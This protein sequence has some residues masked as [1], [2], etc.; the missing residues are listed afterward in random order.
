MK[1]HYL[2]VSVCTLITLLFTA[3]AKINPPVNELYRFNQLGFYP[4]QEKIAVLD[5]VVSGPFYIKEYHSG[6]VVYEGLVSQ[7]R[8][9]AFSEKETVVIPFSQLRTKGTYFIEIPEIGKSLPFEIK[10]SLFSSLSKASLKAFYLQRSGTDIEAEFAGKW[11]R[12]AGH[13]DTLVRIH[14][15][16]ATAVRPAESLISSPKGWYDAGDYNKYIVNSGFT[17]GILLSLYEDYPQYA[18]SVSVQIP[19]SANQ[20]PDLLDEI[21]WNLEWMLSMQDPSDGGVYHKLTTPSFEGMIKP[22]ECKQPRYVIEKSVTATLDFAASMAQA[23]RVFAPFEKDYPEVSQKM[24]QASIRA[25][26]WALQHPDALYNQRKMNAN[27]KPAVSTGGYEDRSATDEFFWAA[28]E[29]YI[30]TGNDKYTSYVKQYLPESFILP[31]WG[32][33]YG[34]AQ[35]SLIRHRDKLEKEMGSLSDSAGKQLVNYAD[36]CL[37]GVELAPYAAAYGRSAKDFFWGCNSD[38]ASNQGIAFLYAYRLTNDRR[39]LTNALHSM[40]YLLGRNATG[41]CYVT[42]FGHKSPLHPHHRLAASD[43]IDEPLPG[44]LV[45]GPNPGKQDGC[46]Y[47][48]LVPDE[49]YVDI[50]PSYASN[51]IAIN[52]QGMFTYYVMALDATLRDIK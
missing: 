21:W 32:K 27:F 38:K 51:E 24:L 29:L 31:V 45:G 26:N 30:T 10:D 6:K 47:P 48:S 8:L 37:A 14:P 19:E 4:S 49:A 23:S 43:G 25:F 46:E 7:P 20:T 22:T 42:G 15:S 34:L 11:E 52:W 17:V 28:T 33:V 40:D 1:N 50:L 12:P 3:C 9:S 18:Q 44:F 16:A 41:Y 5:T 36:S 39:Y 13:P 2:N 35:M